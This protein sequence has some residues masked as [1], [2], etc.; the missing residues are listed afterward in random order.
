MNKLL[1]ASTSLL[2]SASAASGAERSDSIHKRF[3]E[4]VVTGSASPV[5]ERLL[6]YSVSVVGEQR[7]ENSGSTRVLSVISGMV[8]SLFVTERSIFGFGVSSSG[9][10]GHIKMRGVGG[11]RASGVLMMVDGQPQFAGIYSH[12]VAD[13]YAKENVERVEVLRG[14][15]SVLYGSNALA[16]AINV[17]T[18]NPGRRGVRTSLTSQ[19]GSYNT[20]LSSLS[21]TVNYDRFS[22]LVSLSYNRTDGTRK[23]FDFKQA[24]GYVKVGVDLTQQW[25]ATAD[26]TLMNLR[27]NDPIYPT[28]SNPESTDI[29]SQNITRGEGSLTFTNRYASTSGAVRAYYSYGNHFV[30]DPRHFHSL[31]DRLGLI[32]YQTFTPWSGATVT[33]GFDF[34]TYSGKIPM[35][36]GKEHTEG[37]LSTI[38]RKR[39]TEYSPYLTVGQQLFDHRLSLNAG[40]RMANSN[41]F[42]TQ[43][44][45]QFGFSVNP[46]LGLTVK[47]NLAMG[48]RNPSFRE[49]Y[50]YRMANP[51]L[52][53]ERMMNYELAVAKHFSRYISLELTGYFSKGTN[54]IQTLDQKNQNTG[55]FVN[56]GLELTARSHPLEQLT[57]YFT[58]SYLHTSLSDLTGAPEQQYYFGADWT[59]LKCLQIGA[60]L[61]G[62]AGLYVSDGIDR[63]NYA[64]LNMKITWEICRYVSVFTRLENITDARY[65]INR[66]YPMPGFTALGGFTLRL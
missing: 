9:G 50:L 13:F 51:D 52:D 8:P 23:N 43:W 20:W 14:P 35:S 56:K 58:Y 42:H 27:G 40:L 7:L 41:M 11:D 39:I 60:D 55:R 4:L 33:A 17:I 63:Q 54:L 59:P 32:L 28:L 34:D 36:G 45:P 53:P 44:V 3:D 49:L 29:Y 62:I 38:A 1:I 19:Y 46:G 18:R 26:Y 24:E 22:S 12:H 65:V 15:G 66:G 31:D 30:D 37:S 2:L 64:L 48:Y 21:N 6:P 5:A 47:G 57:L 16:G 10:S 61:K 25:K